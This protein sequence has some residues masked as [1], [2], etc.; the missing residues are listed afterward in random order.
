MKMQ[1]AERKKE[2]VSPLLRTFYPMHVQHKE[3]GTM[4]EA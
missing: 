4:V 1:K 2:A 3:W